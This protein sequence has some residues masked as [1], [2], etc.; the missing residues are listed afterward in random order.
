ME[1]CWA[2]S[3]EIAIDPDRRV[4]Q[5][6]RSVFERFVALRSA[7]QVLMEFRSQ[8]IQ[9]PV[10]HPDQRHRSAC[11]AVSARFLCRSAHPGLMASSGA[12][13][14]S[15][16]SAN[17]PNPLRRAFPHNFPPQAVGRAV[18]CEVPGSVQVTIAYLDRRCYKSLIP[19]GKEEPEGLQG[20]PPLTSH[21]R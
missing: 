21:D 10:H 5:A 19:A 15:N 12:G 11:L 13:S 14:L 16:S 17:L 2:P 20:F 4:Q 1:P 9:L 3:G 18:T 7:R 6:I 8:G